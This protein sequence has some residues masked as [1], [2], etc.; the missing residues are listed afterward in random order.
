MQTKNNPEMT[1]AKIERSSAPMKDRGI[2]DSGEAVAV[3]IGAMSQRRI[4]D[5]GIQMVRA[6]L[7][8]PGEVEK[9]KVAA[10]QS[11]NNC[12]GQ[13]LKAQLTKRR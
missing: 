9:L 8:R 13:D 5:F 7:Y 1:T 11:F 2:V 6:G 3:G 10:L 4:Q 12:V